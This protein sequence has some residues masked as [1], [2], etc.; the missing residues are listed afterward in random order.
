MKIFEKKSINEFGDQEYVHVET[1]RIMA[2]NLYAW[3]ADQ[4]WYSVVENHGIGTLTAQTRQGV[5]VSGSSKWDLM[6]VL[7][8]RALKLKQRANL[9]AMKQDLANAK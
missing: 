7:D 5:I 8:E 2:R 4:K 9:E 1:G 3:K 6:R